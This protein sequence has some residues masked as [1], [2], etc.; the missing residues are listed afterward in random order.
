[1]PKTPEVYTHDADGNLTQDGRWTYTWDAEN[2]LVQMIRDTDTP[3]GAR[4]KLVFEYDHQGRRIRKT[5]STY[6]GGWVEQSDVVFLYDL[7]AGQAGG[8][9]LVAELDANAGNA[10]V[11]TY[12]WGTDLSGSL[13]GA[14]GVG[15]LL[16]V[17]YY[18]ST[19]T[20]AFVGFDGNGNVAALVDAA[21]GTVAAR[22][23]YGP[24]A[25]PIRLTGPMAKVNPIRFST[26]YTDAESGLLYYGYRYYNPST[27]RWLSRDPLGE[28][29]G[30][31]LY[32]F[33]RNNP[34][35]R[36]DFL[37]LWATGDHLGLTESSFMDSINGLGTAVSEGCMSRMLGVL[38]SANSG[39]DTSH[40]GAL[41]RHFNRPY[42]QGEGDEERV[43]YRQQWRSNYDAY[44]AREA[45]EFQ[46]K[47][48]PIFGRFVNCKGA[49]QALGRMSHS[50]QDFFGHAIHESSG[51]SG[52]GGAFTASPDDPGA[53]WPSSYKLT[54]PWNPVSEHP[55]MS[56]PRFDSGEY[57]A[58]RNA[59]IQYVKKQFDTYLKQW[60]SSCLCKCYDL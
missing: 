32:G 5:F 20:N 42:V 49:L 22:Y 10:K 18:G 28:D 36:V 39:Q 38:E 8:W 23:E 7:S 16:K 24:F 19:T 4:Q 34:L 12:V 3:S 27:G 48:Q 6:S 43:T 14:G 59:S 13:T 31:N 55:P 9:S 11:R 56:E 25:E 21:N 50:W 41:E 35:N 15:G 30:R 44:L 40:S 37:G 47:L 1:V 29:G 45:G 26:K 51:F 17:T 60:L 57:G 58:R 52:S 33:V 53:Y 2:R 54:A 46:W